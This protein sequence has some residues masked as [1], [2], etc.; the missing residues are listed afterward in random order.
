MRSVS[1]TD[2]LIAIASYFTSGI[3][4]VIWIIATY[5]IFKKTLTNFGAYH[6]YQSIFL[7]ILIYILSMFFSIAYN[8][9]ANLP[10]IGPLMQYINLHLFNLPVY[11]TFSLVH[12]IIFIILCYLSLG[13]LLGKKTYFPF[14][15]DV[16]GSNFRD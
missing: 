1:L 4:G 9:T 3:A 14:V 13:A 5:L 10:F 11:Y 15:S 8:L 7:S 12:F 2:R 16:I 6:I